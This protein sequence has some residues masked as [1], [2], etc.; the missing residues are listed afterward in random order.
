[1]NEDCSEGVCDLG[2]CQFAACDDRVENGNETAPDCGGGGCDAC[3]LGLT[4]KQSSDC[5]SSHCSSNG[6][7][8]SAGCTDGSQNG[9]E[10]DID[11]GG[12]G[13]G[14]CQADQGCELD[15]DCSSTVCTPQD[16][17]A[18]VRCDDSVLNGDESAVDCGGTSCDGCPNLEVCND[19]GDCASGACQ[20]GQCV[21]ATPTGAALSRVGWLATASNSYVDDDPN[22]VLDSVGGR[23]TSGASQYDGMW[24]EVDMGELKTFFSA[25]LKCEEADLDFPTTYDFYL[26]VDG[27]Y[28]EPAQAGLFGGT[29]SEVKFD[30]AQI[31]RYIKFVVRAPKTKWWSID[32]L[33]VLE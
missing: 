11:C 13:C 24:L 26:S 22:E 3:A 6:I 32:E 15:S 25:V 33:N 10:T 21:P 18:A 1:L 8:V 12:P 23:W 4:C 17:C 16:V 5:A 19:G 9:E 31:A 28:G 7:C 30:T 27:T 29:T 14:P 2:F 20:S